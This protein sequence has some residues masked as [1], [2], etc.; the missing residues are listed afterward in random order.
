MGGPTRWESIP[1]LDQLPRVPVPVESDFSQG[2][3]EPGVC[4]CVW[5]WVSVHLYADNHLS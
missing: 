3:G 4:E 1:R 5:V 2:W